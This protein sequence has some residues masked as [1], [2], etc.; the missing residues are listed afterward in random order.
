ML[1]SLVGS[2]MCI[3][4]S[5]NRLIENAN[6]TINIAGKKVIH[7]SPENKK[8]WPTLISVPKL[9]FVGGAPTPRNDRVAS[10]IIA[11]ARVIVAITNTG[12]NTLGRMCRIMILE[13]FKPIK[14]AAATYSFSFSTKVDPLTVLAIETHSDNPMDNIRTEI[15]ISSRSSGGKIPLA[16][17]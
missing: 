8:S 11:K 5:P 7:H 13:W 14:R 6:N 4:D 3:R 1:W 2:E 9:G 17:P 16:T 10:A 15:A 12:L